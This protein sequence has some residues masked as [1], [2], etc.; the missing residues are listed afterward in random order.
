MVNIEEEFVLYTYYN[1][2]LSLQYP[3]LFQ[4][5]GQEVGSALTAV[6]EQAGL[7]DQ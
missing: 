7:R 5:W 6:T 3:S 4:N 2:I 1:E